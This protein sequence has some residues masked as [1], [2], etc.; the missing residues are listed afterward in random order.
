MGK[1]EFSLISGQ[2]ATQIFSKGLG[3][4]APQL[5]VTFIGFKG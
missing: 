4:K 5:L 3:F 1:V 2:L